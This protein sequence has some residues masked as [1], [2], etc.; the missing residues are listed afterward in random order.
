MLPCVAME[1]HGTAHQAFAVLE[2]TT[3]PTQSS[4]LHLSYVLSFAAGI[5]YCTVSV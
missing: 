1:D 2:L 3:H 4:Y 5:R